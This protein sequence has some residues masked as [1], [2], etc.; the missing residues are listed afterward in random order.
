MGDAEFTPSA[1]GFR[2]M[3][4]P[5][6]FRYFGFRISLVASANSYRLTMPKACDNSGLMTSNCCCYF[7]TC[8]LSQRHIVREIRASLSKVSSFISSDNIFIFYNKIRLMISE[9]NQRANVYVNNNTIMKS[10]FI[11]KREEIRTR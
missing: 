8:D 9:I 2:Y 1:G 5:M 11:D 3:G 6:K 4:Q 7:D 10:K